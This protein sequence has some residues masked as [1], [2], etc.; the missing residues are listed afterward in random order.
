MHGHQLRSQVRSTLLTPTSSPAQPRLPARP[1]RL[2]RADCSAGS[3]GLATALSPVPCH[4]QGGD[5]WWKP[6]GLAGPP[7]ASALAHGEPLTGWDESGEV[8]RLQLHLC[9]A[10]QGNRCSVEPGGQARSTHRVKGQGVPVAITPLWE[11]Q[12][13][14]GAPPLPPCNCCLSS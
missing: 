8:R 12:P 3:V 4:H 1:C 9:S 13:P 2:P 5:R 10:R 6:T 7:A 14:D 11:H